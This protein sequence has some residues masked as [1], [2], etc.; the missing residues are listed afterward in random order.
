MSRLL[1]TYFLAVFIG[2]SVVAHAQATSPDS[3]QSA[4]PAPAN[5][6]PKSLTPIEVRAVRADADAPFAK[7]EIS[8]R[9]LQ[10]ENLGQDLPFLLQYTP[11]AVVTS[12]AGAGVGYTGLRIRGTDNTRVNVT[13]NGIPVNDA[14]SQGTYFVD[15]PDLASSTTSIQIQRGIGSSTNGPGAFGGTLSV[16]NLGIYEQPGAEGSISYGS[17]NTQKYTVQ[18]GTGYIHDKFALQVRLS[19][20]TSN[21]FIDRSGSDLKSFQINGAWRISDKTTI[22]GMVLQGIETTHQA[23]NGIPEEKLRGNDS[24][25][26]AHYYNNVGSLYFSAADS[27]N[28]FASNPRKYNVFTYDNQIDHYRQNYYQ[29]FADHHFSPA[30]TGHVGLFLTRGLGYY[31]EY[32]QEQSYSSYG[33][34]P[35]TTEAGDT[36]RHTDLTRQ[37]WLDNYYYGA[38]YSLLWDA[39]KKTKLSLG[40]AAT[41]YIGNHYGYILWS[42]YGGMP[43]HY[44]W[45]KLDAQ[46][47]DFN[48]YAKAEQ[49]I[50]TSMLLY[51]DVQWRGIG[52][53]M[54]GFRNNPDLHPAVTYN[55]FNPKV[56]FTYFLPHTPLMHQKLYASFAAASH[57]PNRD[58]FE[59][60]P[61]DLPKPE[62]LY[63]GEAG[64]ERVTDEYSIA[65]NAYYMHYKDQLVLTGKVND[66]GA[67]TRTNV[68]NSYRA[69]I[70]LQG[71]VKASDWISLHA[72]ATFSQN[73]IKDFVEYVDNY[74]NGVQ[75]AYNHGTSEIAFSPSCIAAGG[76]TLTPFYHTA[77]GKAFSIELL[78]KYVGKQYL[79]NTTNEGRKINP[80]AL[81][82]LRFHYS[83]QLA[84]FRNIGFTLMLNNVLNKEYESNGYTYSYIYGG[85]S[86]TQ[87]FY[88]PQAGFNWLLGVNLKW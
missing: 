15:L 78:E 18:A 30:V 43:E 17:F 41:Q 60:S 8:G 6:A 35:F 40:G 82:D 32:K 3:M 16:A 50:G 28:L 81:L 62:R 74:D 75:E 55:F 46:K 59:A 68:P 12:D 71:A 25:L 37:L 80:Y 1:H 69:G 63:D 67:Y 85:M 53:F 47:N 65:V 5:A 19:Q 44:R 51:G 64:Y 38:V 33:L 24:A 23:W 58:D 27:A 26:L 36:I 84:P 42:Q 21:G 66:V 49:R 7:T 83:P 2:S 88:Y 20:I 10:K 57:E 29:L 54:N 4:I 45:Y 52:Y 39:T 34:Q 87:N 9:S 11:S 76:I 14:E 13:L 79:D 70:E 86:T 72:N 22:Q 48:L 73:R 61:N 31:E 77:K 56:G